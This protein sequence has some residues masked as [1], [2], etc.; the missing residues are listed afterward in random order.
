[1]LVVRKTHSCYGQLDILNFSV[2]VPKNIC[3]TGKIFHLLIVEFSKNPR[4]LK[5]SKIANI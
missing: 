3:L 1:M 5:S 4:F 2:G